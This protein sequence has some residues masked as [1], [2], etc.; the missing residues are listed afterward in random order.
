M[1]VGR[2]Q[3]HRPSITAEQPRPGDPPANAGGA[4]PPARR[5]RRCPP[6][7]G[8][9][10]LRGGHPRR[11]RGELCGLR[12]GDVNLDAGTLTIA[13]SISDAGKEVS[14]K[15]TKT[16]QARRIALDP[17]TVNVLR[18]HRRLAEERAIA[19]GAILAPS[20]YVWSQDLDAM[21]PYRPDRVTGA[22][23]SLRDRLQLPH[24]TFH[25]LRH[26]AA[27][28][29]AGE[30]VGIRTIAGRLGHASPSVTLRT[31]AHFLDASDR[32]A[33][34]AIGSVVARLTRSPASEPVP[35]PMH[36]EEPRAADLA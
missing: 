1:G 23:R 5:L 31:Y 21:T 34:D 14:V 8:Q 12:W 26:F 29:L 13:R 16:H 22:F 32:D 24:V 20:A 4:G 15:D 27:T 10:R 30:G 36:G 25:A 18:E 9:P 11:R 2:P 35:P 3:P 28:T 17:S 19:A 7:S 33:A 6:G